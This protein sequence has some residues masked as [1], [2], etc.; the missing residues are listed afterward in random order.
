MEIRVPR[1]EHTAEIPQNIPRQRGHHAENSDEN[2][3]ESH[4]AAG[5]MRGLPSPVQYRLGIGLS[6][7][8]RARLDLPEVR[9][10]EL[11]TVALREG[12]W[13]GSGHAPYLPAD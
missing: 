2:D 10:G 11:S 7:I 8:R 6:A 3:R 12:P 13:R 1:P 4:L 9:E 5:D